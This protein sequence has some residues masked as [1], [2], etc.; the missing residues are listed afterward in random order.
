MIDEWGNEIKENPLINLKQSIFK[1]K[2]LLLLLVGIFVF[3][4]AI[5]QLFSLLTVKKSGENKSAPT[6]FP[7]QITPKAQKRLSKVATEAAFLELEANVA[8]LSGKID[9]ID[10]YE[11]PLVFPPVDTKVEFEQK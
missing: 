8:S 11:S 2:S 7:S 4:I 5:V 1:N 10:L 3:T 6:I 9:Q